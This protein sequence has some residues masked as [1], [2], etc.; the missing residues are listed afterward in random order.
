MIGKF[1]ELALLALVRAGPNAHAAKVYEVL[2]KTQSKLPA[3]AA[4][5]TALDR[6]VAKKLVSETKDPSDKRAK[7]LFT[8]TGEGN[9]ALREALN[10]TQSIGLPAGWGV[11]HV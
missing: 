5:Y 2:E 10:A 11:A 9:A 7:R 3:F 1:E 8:I 6:M 4:L